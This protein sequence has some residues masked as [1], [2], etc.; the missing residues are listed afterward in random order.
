MKRNFLLL[1]VVFAT[2]AFI[3]A[4]SNSKKE[5]L[6]NTWQMSDIAGKE[7]EGLDDSTKQQMF[8]EAL[9]EF[10][11]DGKYEMKKMGG[12][13]T[14]TWKFGDGEKTL[15]T[16]E[17]GSDMID[18]VHIVELTSG[19]LVVKDARTDLTITFKPNK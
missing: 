19:K 12:N 14:G 2:A 16:T 13:K 4:C 17:V 15:I 7:T 9:V 6:V 18:T 11:S 8:R 5:Q 3:S 1:I 10:R